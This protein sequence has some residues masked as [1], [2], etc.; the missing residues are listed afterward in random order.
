MFMEKHA[1]CTGLSNSDL[2][3]SLLLIQ[4]RLC[5]NLL[6]VGRN[7]IHG[8]D[9]VENAN[10][11]IALWF[12]GEWHCFYLVPRCYGSCISAWQAQ[13]CKHSVA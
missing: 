2:R 10:K 12:G 6:Q 8:S 1:C 13:S 9:S 11:E 4:W 7:V 3:F 5:V